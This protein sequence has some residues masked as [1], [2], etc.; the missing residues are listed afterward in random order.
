MEVDFEDIWTV[1][2]ESV[3]RVV[4]KLNAVVEF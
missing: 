2:G 4:S 3:D 1:F